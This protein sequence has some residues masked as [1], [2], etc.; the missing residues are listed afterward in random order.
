MQIK[1]YLLNLSVKKIFLFFL[2]F[3][4]LDL[5]TTFIG[6]NLGFSERNPLARYF[7]SF[8]FVGYFFIFEYECAFFLTFSFLL[9]K[10]QLWNRSIALKQK[11]TDLSFIPFIFGIVLPSAIKSSAIINN[12]SLILQWI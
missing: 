3:I 12:I 2:I 4:I 8:G 9:K 1:N 10:A 7:L 5:L 11:K 6:L